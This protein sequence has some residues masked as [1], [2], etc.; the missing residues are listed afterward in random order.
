MPTGLPVFHH[1]F[2]SGTP[3][4][5]VAM[6]L[7]RYVA[8]CMPL[9]HADISTARRRLV[10]LVV[11]WIAS[12]G[13]PLT[14]LYAFLSSME[15]LMKV[16][17]VVCFVE[18]LFIERWKTYMRVAVLK[19]YFLCM[20]IAVIFTYF[21]IVKAARAVASNDKKSSSKG[22]KTVLL[23]AIQLLLCLIQFLNP[24]IESA[25]LMVN[26]R[27]FV[28]IRYF[29]FV[30]FVVAPRCLSPLVYGLRDENFFSVLK[31]YA[32]CGLNKRVNR[33]VNQTSIRT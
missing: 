22:Q 11:I 12:V 29:N 15:E 10:G 23:H 25:L 31:C 32:V 7:E 21:K 20:C 16:P 27:L 6:C 4:T 26:F 17:T 9:R 30:V 2:A 19:F 8:I 3:L 1:S 14:L 24:F 18:I 28:D 33:R 5:L 13:P